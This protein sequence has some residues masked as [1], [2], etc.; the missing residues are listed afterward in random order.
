[1][2]QD[3]LSLVTGDRREVHH[4]SSKNRGRGAICLG[5]SKVTRNAAVVH[6]GNVPFHDM[7]SRLYI[8]QDSDMRSVVL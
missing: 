5:E 2:Y 6:Y 3:L 7:L 1:L 8:G 4:R